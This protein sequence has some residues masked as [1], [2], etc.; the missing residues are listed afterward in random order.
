MKNITH[1]MVQIPAGKTVMDMLP[2]FSE[3]KSFLGPIG[4]PCKVC[5][6][7]EK[8]FSEVRKPRMSLR[9]YPIHCITPISFLYRVCGRCLGLYR[10]GGEHRDDVLSAIEKFRMGME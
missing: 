9:L 2:Q 6:C 3:V 1:G 7:C 4:T 8:P 10:R 5:A